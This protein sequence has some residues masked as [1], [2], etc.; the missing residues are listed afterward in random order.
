LRNQPGTS[1]PPGGDLERH[2]ERVI[3][4]RPRPDRCGIGWRVSRQYARSLARRRPA[5]FIHCGGSR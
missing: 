5:E 4:R 1:A 3:G 2:R